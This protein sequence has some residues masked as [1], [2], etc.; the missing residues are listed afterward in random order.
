M[1]KKIFVVIAMTFSACL[2]QAGAEIWFR[3]WVPPAGA[4]LMLAQD[5]S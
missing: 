4:E 2:H 1:M 5:S 3:G